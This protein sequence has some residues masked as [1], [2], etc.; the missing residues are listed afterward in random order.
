MEQCL[1]VESRDPVEH[2]DFDRITELALGMR[3]QGVSTSLFLIDNA[4]FGARAG[5]AP[6]LA[7]LVEQRI[8][9][10]ADRLAMAERGI[11]EDAI[12]PGIRATDI[13]TVVDS[14]LAGAAVL[15]R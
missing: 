13:G 8:A 6:G 14:L 7:S 1:I 4:V 15:W 5:V 11:G 12:L 2:R 9:V 3:Q 10:S